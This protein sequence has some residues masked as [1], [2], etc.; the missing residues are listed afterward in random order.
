MS[1]FTPAA[2]LAG[3]ECRWLLRPGR[4]AAALGPV[5]VISLVNLRGP[6]DPDDRFQGA[7]ITIASSWLPLAIPLFAGITAGSLAEDR[8]RGIMLTLFARGLSRGQYFFA[9]GLGAAVSSAL[10]TLGGLAIFFLLAWFMAPAGRSTSWPDLDY[11]GPVPALFR[12]SPLGNDLLAVVMYMAAAAA[13]S[14]AGLLASAAGANEYVAMVTPLLVALLSLFVMGEPFLPLSPFSYL[15]LQNDYA[16]L[17][18]EGLRPY[19]AFFYWLAFGS[20]AAMLGKWLF[21]RR[22]IA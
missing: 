12:V 21:A 3:N 20:G 5:V 8:R 6:H 17:F 7:L 19:A 14:L 1:W 11:P 15:N 13:L 10:L 22:E 16:P 9:K 2:Y 18:A 4:L